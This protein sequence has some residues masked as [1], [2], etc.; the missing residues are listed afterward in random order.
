MSKYILIQADGYNLKHF[1]ESGFF[2][3]KGALS[4]L[5]TLKTLF[6]VKLFRSLLGI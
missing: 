6:A 3:I 4:F 2:L 1:T 5:I